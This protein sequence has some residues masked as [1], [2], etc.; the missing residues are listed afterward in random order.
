MF[1]IKKNSYQYLLLLFTL[2]SI[3]LNIFIFIFPQEAFAMAPSKDFRMDF[4]GDW[5]YV[6]KDPYSYF[7]PPVKSNNTTVMCDK[8]H[9]FTQKDLS[10]G[11]SYY[12]SRYYKTS[13]PDYIIPDQPIDTIG[14]AKGGYI[15]P[16][17]GSHELDSIPDFNKF[18]SKYKHERE[19]LHYNTKLYELDAYDFDGSSISTGVDYKAW[20]KHQD[21]AR[22]FVL[23]FDWDYEKVRH[24]MISRLSLGIKTVNDTIVYIYIKCQE[25]GRRKILWNIWE[26][27][28]GKYESYKH[29]K[30]SWDNNTSIWS[31]IEKD[32]RDDIKFE[33]EDLL[34]VKKIKKDLKRSVKAEVEKLLHEKQPFKY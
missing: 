8:C 7:H 1:S 26:K 5:E 9:Y 3:I 32:V 33:I 15:R 2:F 20:K 21:F 6:G 18:Q 12:V 29:F 13:N 23:D 10:Q 24:G 28:R 4:Y 27:N 16:K 14:T 25:V 34:G 31:K 30:R 22:E 11:P 19:E 17:P